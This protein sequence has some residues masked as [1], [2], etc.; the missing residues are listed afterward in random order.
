MKA[1]KELC[2]LWEY[3]SFCEW[4]GTYTKAVD[5]AKRIEEI[6]KDHPVLNFFARWLHP[7]FA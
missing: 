5:T 7:F 3:L 6:A 4:D 1:F 2:W